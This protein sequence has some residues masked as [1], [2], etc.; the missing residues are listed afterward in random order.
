MSA[1]SLV[2][3]CKLCNIQEGEEKTKL[4]QEP[5]SPNERILVNPQH[6]RPR[7]PVQ[8][9]G[10]RMEHSPIFSLKCGDKEYKPYCP[11]EGFTGMYK[12]SHQ[13]KYLYRLYGLLWNAQ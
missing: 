2:C 10:G 6:P 4:K 8:N 9:H 3:V 11:A 1:L 5:P 12:I 7:S 13:F